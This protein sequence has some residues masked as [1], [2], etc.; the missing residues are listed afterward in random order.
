MRHLRG[1]GIDEEEASIRRSIDEKEAF[2]RRR[3]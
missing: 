1:G 3:Q 2:K